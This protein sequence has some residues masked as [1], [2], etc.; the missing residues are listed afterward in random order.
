MEKIPLPSKIEIQPG[1]NKN[2]SIISIQPC[3]PGYGTTLGN[4]LRRVLLSSLPGGAVTA[5]KIK[6]VSHEFSTIPYVKEDAVEISLNLKQLRLKVFSEEPVRLELKAKGE[7]KVTAKDIKTTSDVEIVNPE[8]VI[9]TLTNKEAEFD[10]EILVSQGR[11][12]I[13]TESREKENV[14]IDMIIIDAIFTPIKNVGIKIENIRVGQM[15]NYENLILNIETD[16]SLTPQ[17]ALNQ[18]NQILIDHFQFVDEQIKTTT[19]P[20]KVKKEKEKEQTEETKKITETEAVAEKEEIKTPKKRGR[21]PKAKIAEEKK[22][23]N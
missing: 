6:G 14:E 4:A 17:E 3:H 16:G 10:M 18:A 20:T 21:K 11:G 1:K 23:G 7:K 15:T 5:F 13:P 19:T 22:E 8:L 2:E 12:Y 9:A